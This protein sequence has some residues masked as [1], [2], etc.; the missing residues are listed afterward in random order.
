MVCICYI[1]IVYNNAMEFVL[2]YISKY[3]GKMETNEGMI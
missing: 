3:S 2:I 1:Y